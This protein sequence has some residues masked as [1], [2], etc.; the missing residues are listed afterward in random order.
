M[1][2]TQN[3][4]FFDCSFTRLFRVVVILFAFSFLVQFY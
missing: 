2:G 1:Q 3:F 4:L